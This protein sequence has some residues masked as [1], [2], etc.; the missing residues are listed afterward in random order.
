MNRRTVL[1]GL[2]TIVAGSGGTLLLQNDG[3]VDQAVDDVKELVPEDVPF[4]NSQPGVYSFGPLAPGFKRAEWTD[5]GKLRVEFSENHDMDG[6]GLRYHAKDS[7]NDDIVTRAAP[8]YGGAVELNVLGRFAQMDARPPAGKYHLVAYKGSFGGFNF[9][10][11]TLGTASLGIKPDLELVTA[12]VT[13][14]GRL[15]LQLR[16]KGNAPAIVVSAEANGRSARF[17]S[18]VSLE[19]ALVSSSD[20]PFTEGDGCAPQPSELEVSLQTGPKMDVSGT[21]EPVPVDDRC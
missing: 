3:D 21:F 1:G 11:E 5:R 13:P 8:Q 17:N 14:K 10:Q 12:S 16:N 7:V 18:P 4:M 20:R 6:F 15:S 2:A 9:V 19:G